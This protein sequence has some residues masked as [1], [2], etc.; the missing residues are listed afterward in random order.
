VPVVSRVSAAV[1][2]L[3]RTERLALIAVF[4]TQR[5]IRFPLDAVQGAAVRLGWRCA[6]TLLAI[7]HVNARS[8]VWMR[9]VR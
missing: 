5:K 9:N 1:T 3:M 8:G 2:S 4:V 7:C 6:R